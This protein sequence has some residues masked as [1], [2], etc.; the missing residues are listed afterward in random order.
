[1][2]AHEILPGLWLGDENA[3]HDS[4]FIQNENIS[5]IVNCTS[6][7]V[8][9]E[10]VMKHKCI[11]KYRLNIINPGPGYGLE[12][13]NIRL[14]SIHISKLTSIIRYWHNKGKNILVHCHSGAQRSAAVIAAYLMRFYFVHSP[15]RY[16]KSCSFV[17]KKRNKAFYYGTNVNFEKAIN[18]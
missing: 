12:N 7:I 15:N 10:Y 16:H 6:E 13:D 2:S 3:A 1:M 8:F 18:F 14:M 4:I 5:V 9:S 11:K 17:H